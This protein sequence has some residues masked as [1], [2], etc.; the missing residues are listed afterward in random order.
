MLA[1][2]LF[3]YFFSTIAVFAAVMVIVSRNTVYA[4][5]F[6]NPSFYKYFNLIY[7]DRC[8]IFRDDNAD[9]ICRSCCGL[10]S[11]CCYDV[12]YYRA[13]N[14]EIQQKGSY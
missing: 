7:Y 2:S 9:C 13:T 4:V 10:I 11:L 6:F 1:H 14:K 8:R 3:F 5:F 12:E